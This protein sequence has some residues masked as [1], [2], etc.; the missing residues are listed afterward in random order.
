M[1]DLFPNGRSRWRPD[2]AAAAHDHSAISRAHGRARKPLVLLVA[3]ALVGAAPAL[4][5]RGDK[6]VGL[7]FGG[8]VPTHDF[9]ES[10]KTG[11]EVGVAGTYMHSEHAGVCVDVAYHRWPGSDA[12]NALVSLLGPG[13]KV[14][15]DAVQATLQV[16]YEF[17]TDGR[18]RPHANGGGGMYYV[19]S[20]LT[21][22]VGIISGDRQQ[23]FGY[24]VGAGVDLKVSPT[25]RVGFGGT[26]HHILTSG[27][28]TDLFTV[29]L[30]LMFGTGGR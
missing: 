2:S 30:S 4:A 6:W 20:R 22:P 18:A 9:A 11:F 27:S 12:A 3:L 16:R 29:G 24:V 17:R 23:N 7:Q 8:S 5:A 10:A 1:A 15:F 19:K 13:S 25:Q 14:T 21:T 28:D 26:Y